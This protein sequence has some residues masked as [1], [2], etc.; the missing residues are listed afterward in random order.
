M[1]Q[2]GEI[3]VSEGKRHFWDLFIAGI[4]FTIAIALILAGIYLSITASELEQ[5]YE[6]IDTFK[7]AIIFLLLGLEMSIVRSLYFDP[8]HRRYKKQSSLGP[9]N[10]GRWH[11]MPEI[12]YVSI[13]KQNLANGGEIF[14][15]N[16]WYAVNKHIVVYDNVELQ[17]AFELA[18]YLAIKLRVDFLDASDPHDKKWLEITETDY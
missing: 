17:P 14:N 13:F 11:T 9:F 16:I 5:G 1:K 3:I 4:W 12:E 18:R 8:V 10:L 15:V 6:C 7:G 2:T